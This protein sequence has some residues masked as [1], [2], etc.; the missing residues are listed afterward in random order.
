M[1][2]SLTLSADFFSQGERTI[3]TFGSTAVSCFRFSTGVEAVRIRNGVG[4]V[5]LLPFQGQQVWDASF[6]GRRF[7]MKSMF[8]EPVPNVPFLQTYGGFLLGA[9]EPA[10]LGCRA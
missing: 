8:S 7:T 3:A 4:E 1:D 6:F 9:L 10:V 5:V 2:A